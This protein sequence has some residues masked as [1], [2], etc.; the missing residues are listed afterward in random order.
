MDGKPLDRRLDEA[1]TVE[2]FPVAEKMMVIDQPDLQSPLIRVVEMFVS[3]GMWLAFLYILQLVV[4]SL[5]WLTGG[6]LICGQVF[7]PPE[8][9]ELKTLLIGTLAYAAVIF[10]A[11][12]GWANWNYWRYGRLERRKPRPP[13]ADETV[14]G[15]FGVSID[16]VRQARR[17]KQARVLPQLSG[18]T[19]DVVMKMKD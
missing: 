15:H 17:A 8:W 4:T 19:L 14:A 2:A 3:A 13:V 10:G 5:A 9:Q 12:W 1:K 16:V 7:L 6:V 18:L 11:L